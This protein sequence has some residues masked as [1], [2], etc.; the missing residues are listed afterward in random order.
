MDNYDELMS[1]VFK[2]R[3][4]AREQILYKISEEIDLT[5]ANIA[6]LSHNNPRL[7]RQLKA[8]KE[9]FDELGIK[10]RWFEEELKEIKEYE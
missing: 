6:G 4:E 7:L 5:M 10:C 9:I 3:Q 8:L 1:F 2:H